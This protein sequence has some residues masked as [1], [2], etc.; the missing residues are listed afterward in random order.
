MGEIVNL[1]K[2]LGSDLYLLA[3][4]ILPAVSVIRLAIGAIQ[5]AAGADDALS[6]AWRDVIIAT[7]SMIITGV[8]KIVIEKLLSSQAVEVW[9]V[10]R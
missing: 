2:G 10:F 9:R 3:I 4:L 8:F 6:T 7:I 1:I 5:K